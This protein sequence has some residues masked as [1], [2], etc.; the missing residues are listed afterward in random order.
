[1]LIE[2][3]AS[4]N[5]ATNDHAFSRIKDEKDR[6]SDPIRVNEWVFV[7]KK[8]RPQPPIQAHVRK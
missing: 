3:W 6:F 2:G 7:V 4:V 5:F 8:M 1:M